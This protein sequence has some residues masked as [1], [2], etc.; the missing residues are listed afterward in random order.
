MASPPLLAGAVNVT[1]ACISPAVAIPI[2]GAPGTTA[3]TENVCV[4]V[5]AALYAP[6]PAWSASIVHLP[7]AKKANIPLL[8]TVQTPVVDD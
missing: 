4:T 5:V 7:A 3:M 1:V 8:V 6:S 2:V